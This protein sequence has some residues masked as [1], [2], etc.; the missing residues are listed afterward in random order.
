MNSNQFSSSA[1]FK[2]LFETVGSKQNAK[3]EQKTIYDMI[4]HLSGHALPGI[5]HN[6]VPPK[7]MDEA[8]KQYLWQHRLLLLFL[9]YCIRFASSF[10]I[11]NKEF[12]TFRTQG[13]CTAFIRPEYLLPFDLYNVYVQMRETALSPSASTEQ[14]DPE[15][16][17]EHT[18]PLHL[19]Q[20]VFETVS[21][22]T[23]IDVLMQTLKVI[24]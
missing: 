11:K 10:H 9:K 22:K 13:S 20:E 4:T 16:A 5:P 23:W 6:S 7:K 19:S 17:Q 24:F 3:E 18:K 14:K 8:M 15:F 2:R 1:L 12:R 21:K